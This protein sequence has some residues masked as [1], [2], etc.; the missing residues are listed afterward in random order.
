MKG[1]VKSDDE[2]GFGDR[3]AE[4]K[5]R[6]QRCFECDLNGTSE[7]CLGVLEV[8]PDSILK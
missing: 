3:G 6:R 4:V 1:K 5:R 7:A 8:K 2:E